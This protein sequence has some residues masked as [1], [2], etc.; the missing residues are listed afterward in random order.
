MLEEEV[1]QG[2]ETVTLALLPAEI[3]RIAASSIDASMT[4]VDSISFYILRLARVIVVRPE[5]VIF[6]GR[7]VQTDSWIPQVNLADLDGFARSVSRRHA[8]IRPLAGGYEITDL[9]STNGSR[10]DG[11]RLVANKAY[12]LLSGAQLTVGQ[13]Q[14]MVIYHP[15]ASSWPK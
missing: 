4:P 8:M 2:P 12:P 10:L 15:F 3:S 7:N 6:I 5:G 9:G 1:D 14:L 13:E 11:R